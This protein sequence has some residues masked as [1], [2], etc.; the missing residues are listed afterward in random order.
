M[1]SQASPTCDI[2][3]SNE[4]PISVLQAS[5]FA[6]LRGVCCLGRNFGDMSAINFTLLSSICDEHEFMSSIEI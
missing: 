5:A 4:F 3:C 2:R 1:T 6:S